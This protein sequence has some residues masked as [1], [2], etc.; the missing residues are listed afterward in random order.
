MEWNGPGLPPFNENQHSYESGMC[1]DRMPGGMQLRQDST[2]NPTD[3]AFHSSAPAPVSVAI[4]RKPINGMGR[5]VGARDPDDF[6]LHMVF[7]YSGIEWLERGDSEL[8]TS[9]Y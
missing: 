5:T 9:P 2:I 1:A 4:S 3:T 8:I 6:C 7:E